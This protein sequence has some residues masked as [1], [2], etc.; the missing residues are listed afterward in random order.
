MMSAC[1]PQEP[2]ETHAAIPPSYAHKLR[3]LIVEDHADT[4]YGLKMY[5]T[6]KG[7]AVQVALDTKTAREIAS[8]NDFDIVL[9]D[10]ALPDGSG[11]DLLRELR[12]RGPVRAIA[13]S[14]HNEPE[15]IAR[16]KE[17]GFLIHLAKP[18]AM[19]EVDRVFA[20]TMKLSPT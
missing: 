15:D 6:N 14:G 3:I 10:L 4:A 5:F 19:A 20:E 12:A 2:K 7:H 13:M 18:M 16:S 9:S 8:N 1:P 17:A 11:W